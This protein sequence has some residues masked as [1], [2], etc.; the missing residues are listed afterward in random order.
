MHLGRRAFLM[1]LPRNI[2]TSPTVSIDEGMIMEDLAFIIG[3]L[4]GIVVMT[5]HEYIRFT[6]SRL[7]RRK[8]TYTRLRRIRPVRRTFPYTG[9]T[10]RLNQTHNRPQR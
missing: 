3:R 8:P 1:A 6:I 2:L 7:H 9:E 4:I 10:Q 5:I